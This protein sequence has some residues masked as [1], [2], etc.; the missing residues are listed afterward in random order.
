MK[1]FLFLSVI[2]SM[3][4][5]AC[6]EAPEGQQ[7]EAKEAEEIEQP[8]S[9]ADTLMVDTEGSSVAWVA[10]EPGE[11]GHN[12][13]IYL[14]GGQLYLTDG[15]ITGGEFVIDMKSIDVKDLQGKGKT[16]LEGHLQGDDFFQA[17]T[18]PTATFTIARVEESTEDSTVSHLITG[19]LAMMDSVKS[20]QI[21]A[22]VSIAES[23]LS[24]ETPQFTIDRTQWGVQYRSGLI[25]TIADKIIDDQIGLK[26]DLKASK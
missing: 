11:E 1:P 6:T 3:F 22:N 18:Y 24:A 19:N 12:G 10:T 9:A 4:L 7:V 15:A 20:I 25:G 23:S 21:P 16:K 5:F 17:E 8:T 26:I 2:V 13:L 14:Q